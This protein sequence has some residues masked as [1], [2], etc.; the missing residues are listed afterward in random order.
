MYIEVRA[1]LSD[2]YRGPWF[3]YFLGLDALVIAYFPRGELLNR[4]P[5]QFGL[6]PFI[7]ILSLD[8]FLTTPD[9]DLDLRLQ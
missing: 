9:F 7:S 4:L 3:S 1:L 5:S 6:P 8:L 2:S